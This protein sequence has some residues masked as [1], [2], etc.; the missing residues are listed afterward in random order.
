LVEGAAAE[1]AD[2]RAVDLG[3]EGE[4]RFED[5]NMTRAAATG[6]GIL[7]SNY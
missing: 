3:A 1:A 6:A 4:A 7:H 5:R 2:S